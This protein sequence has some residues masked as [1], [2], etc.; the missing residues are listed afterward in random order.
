[1]R[2][3]GLWQGC[4]N[5]GLFTTT[6]ILLCPA[7]PK[8][9]S[10]QRHLMSCTWHSKCISSVA[11]LAKREEGGKKIR[12]ASIEHTNENFSQS[13]RY[14]IHSEELS[15]WLALRE[16]A[17]AVTVAVNLVWLFAPSLYTTN[18]TQ[19]KGSLLPVLPPTWYIH[20]SLFVFRRTRQVDFLLAIVILPIRHQLTIMNLEFYPR[21]TLKSAATFKGWGRGQGY[22]FEDG[23]A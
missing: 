18:K 21:K 10:H 12:K 9:R 15:P 3:V 23:S 2:G 14:A 4:P 1:M 16:S 20:G 7:F 13:L 5:C 22:K 19:K 6:T 11:E 8:P 17:A